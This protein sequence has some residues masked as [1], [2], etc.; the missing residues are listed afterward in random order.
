MLVKLMVVNGKVINEDII[1]YIRDEDSA[2]DL[3]EQECR[4][5]FCTGFHVRGENRN[6]L[7][8]AFNVR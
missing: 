1:K 7:E 3:P 4:K 2:G 6:V 8:K 5:I